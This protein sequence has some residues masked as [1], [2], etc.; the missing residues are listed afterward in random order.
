MPVRPEIESLLRRSYAAFNDKD[1]DAV[2][3][4]MHSDIDWPDMLTGRRGSDT[5]QSASTGQDN[6]R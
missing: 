5:R 4:T 2:L 1:V 6:S 3:A